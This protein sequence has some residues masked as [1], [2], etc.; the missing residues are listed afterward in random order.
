MT[1]SLASLALVSGCAVSSAPG[2]EAGA[3]FYRTVEAGDWS[4]ACAWLA[5]QTRTEL[6]Q[7]AGTACPEAL[8][9]EYLPQPGAV[10]SSVAYG[11]M[12]LVRF[13]HDTVFVAR[14]QSGWKVMAAGC[15]PVP[16]HPYEC[17]LQG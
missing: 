11:T 16:G 3:G 7:S 17:E 2:R 6:E 12:T 5:P 8:A 10:G 4:A 1:A 15:S 9:D 13:A 14:F